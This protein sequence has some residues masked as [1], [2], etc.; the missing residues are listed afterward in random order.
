MQ[1]PLTLVL[2]ALRELRAQNKIECYGPAERPGRAAVR[3]IYHIF[4]NIYTEEFKHDRI[5]LR[6]TIMTR[7]PLVPN[8]LPKVHALPRALLP[9]ILDSQ[10]VKWLTML[11]RGRDQQCWYTAWHEGRAHRGRYGA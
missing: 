1:A 9:W 3:E 11:A 6:V 10:R 8:L 7:F 5:R 4:R 2:Q